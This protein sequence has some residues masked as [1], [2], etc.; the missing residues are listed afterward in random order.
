MSPPNEWIMNHPEI[1]VGAKYI[2]LIFDDLKFKHGEVTPSKEFLCYFMEMFPNEL[3]VYLK[4][5]SKFPLVRIQYRKGLSNRYILLNNISINYYERENN[6][7]PGKCL[8][9]NLP[10]YANTSNYVNV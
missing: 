4:E 3:N 2:Y 9:Y 6:L 7:L 8:D 1:S 10:N 5:L